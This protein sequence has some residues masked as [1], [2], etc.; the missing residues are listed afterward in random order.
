MKLPIGFGTRLFFRVV[1][2]GAVLAPACARITQTILV[3]YKVHIPI[4][5]ALPIAIVVF[6]LFFAVLDVPIYMALEGRR[7]WPTWLWSYCLH[8][9]RRRLAGLH[10][11]MRRNDTSRMIGRLSPVERSNFDRLYI[12]AA[13]ILSAFPISLKTSAPTASSPTRLGNLIAAY[14]QYPRLKYGLDAV[15]FWPRVWVT[16]D[17][18]LREEIDSQQAQADGLLYLATALGFS[19]FV[20][21][22]YAIADTIAPGSLLYPE[23]P[24][25][26]CLAATVCLL[27]SALVYRISLYSHAQFGELF[28]S[29]FD[30][31]RSLLDTE[32]IVDLVSNLTDDPELRNRIG[33][34]RNVAVWRLLR[35]HRVRLPGEKVNRKVRLP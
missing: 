6:G 7:F 11:A 8:R 19:S 22:G 12:E 26:E 10:R 17:K 21:L 29:V 16:I 20:V 35:W 28:K 3:F 14:E 13:V 33:I 5:Y 4:E 34:L 23:K 1:F 15:F 18:E 2:P 27:S 25:W 24:I 31:H 30:Q 9:E 32:E